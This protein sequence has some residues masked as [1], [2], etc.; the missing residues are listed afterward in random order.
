SLNGTITLTSP[1]PPGGSLVTFSDTSGLLTFQPATISIAPGATTGTFAVTGVTTGT[2]TLL[3]NALGYNTASASVTV[4]MLAAITLLSIISGGPGLSVPSPV[5]LVTGAP[6]GVV[7]ITLVSSD[8]SKLTISPS[9]VTIP[10][11]ANTPSQQPTVTGV[12]LGSADV[13]ASAPGFF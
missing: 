3:A 10:Q 1:A 4:T 9:T 11:G 13:S 12:G 7:T 8:P 5:S 6:V 2:T